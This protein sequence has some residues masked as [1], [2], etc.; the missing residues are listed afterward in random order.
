MPHIKDNNKTN[1]SQVTGLCAHHCHWL[2]AYWL[3]MDVKIIVNSPTGKDVET[4][5]MF[6]S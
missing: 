6:H 1:I 3:I 4:F 5:I 2:I